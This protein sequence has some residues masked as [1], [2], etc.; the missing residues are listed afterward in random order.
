MQT[1]RRVA[2]QGG[3]TDDE[4]NPEGERDV[5]DYDGKEWDPESCAGPSDTEED[6]GPGGIK[7]WH[8]KEGTTYVEPGVQ[9][10]EDPNPAGSPIGPYPLPS[11]Y[12]GTCGVTLDGWSLAVP[13]SP[14]TIDAKVRIETGC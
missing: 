12:A 14:I 2:Y 8:D 11:A 5:Y 10:Y 13:D 6:C 4:G 9:V 7:S 1:E 3:R